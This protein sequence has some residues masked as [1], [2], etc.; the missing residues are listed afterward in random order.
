[1]KVLPV[2]LP[3]GRARLATRPAAIGSAMVAITIGIVAVALRAAS[4][5][6]VPIVTMA[7]TFSATSSSAIAGKCCVRS[8]AMRRSTTRLCPSIQPSSRRPCISGS[9]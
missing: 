3:P 9:G 1:M 4:A 8:P 5:A 6:G 7:S 2:T